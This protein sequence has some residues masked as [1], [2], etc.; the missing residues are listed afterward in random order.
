MAVKAHVRAFVR[1]LD[2][3]EPWD[4]RP[5]ATRLAQAFSDQAEP[6]VA[7]VGVVDELRVGHGAVAMSRRH[8]EPPVPLTVKGLDDFEALVLCAAGLRQSLLQARGYTL[9][10][11]Q[12]VRQ[13][14]RWLQN[15][16]RMEPDLLDELLLEL[17][18]RQAAS[19]ALARA[20]ADQGALFEQ[21]GADLHRQGRELLGGRTTV[22]GLLRSLVGAGPDLARG[23]WAR[24]TRAV[25]VLTLLDGKG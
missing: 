9:D 16:L 5:T 23:E 2:Q 18:A 4:P 8:P 20:L 17:A 25:V 7:W 6:L 22:G 12:A 3:A 21:A 15:L 11:P 24:W 14:S 13:A 1:D 10:D 19:P